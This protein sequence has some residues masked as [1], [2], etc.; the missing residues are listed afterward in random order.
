MALAL[1]SLCLYAASAGAQQDGGAGEGGREILQAACTGCHDTALISNAKKS[2]EQWQ[3]TVADMV[4]RGAPVIEGERPVL[5]QFLAANYGMETGAAPAAPGAPSQPTG[6]RG[7]SRPDAQGRHVVQ[8]ACSVCHELELI[9][10]SRRS[11]SEWE[12]LVNDMI[13]RGAALLDG[14]REQLLQ[15]LAKYY[16]PE[17][18][19]TNINQ[20]SSEQLIFRFRPLTRGGGGG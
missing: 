16:A 2:A 10:Q 8:E 9:Y 14:E 19:R 7:M 15:F 17:H 18:P 5:V 3:A 13:G 6:S 1:G 12:Q 20:A 11:S 4:E